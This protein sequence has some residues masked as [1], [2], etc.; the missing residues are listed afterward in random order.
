MISRTG[1]HHV[2]ALAY[3]AILPAG[4]YAGAPLLAHAIGAPRNYLGKLLQSLT[5]HGLIESRKGAGGGFRLARPA[6][7]I[8]LLQILEPIEQLS[9]LSSCF[10]GEPICSNES[11]CAVHHRWAGVRDA[12]L[13]L[14][15][16]TTLGDLVEGHAPPDVDGFQLGKGGRQP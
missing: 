13:A 1:Q 4:T 15:A 9:S 5:R 3:L 8:T 2:R 6:R 7:E 11:A 14:L 12:Y 16:E 10:L